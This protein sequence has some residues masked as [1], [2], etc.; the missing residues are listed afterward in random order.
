MDNWFS[1]RENACR[2]K[3][4]ERTQGLVCAATKP[5]E[6]TRKH[7]IGFALTGEDRQKQN[8]NSQIGH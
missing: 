4:A 6:A 1:T 2:N 8:L 7:I 3:F 5:L